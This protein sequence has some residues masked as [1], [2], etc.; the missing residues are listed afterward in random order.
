MIRGL[1]IV[2]VIFYIVAIGT[3][4]LQLI[5][6]FANGINRGSLVIFSE[7][8]IFLVF[9]L[10]FLFRKKIKITAG[11]KLFWKF[12]IIGYIG[13]VIAETAYIFSKPLHKNLFFDLLLVTPWYIMWMICWYFVFKKYDF[14]VKEAFYLGGFHGFVIEGLIAGGLILNPV[15]G[16]LLLPVLTLVYGCFF[17]IPY[18]LT[19]EQFKKQ[20]KVSLGKKVLISLI[21][22][23]AYIPGFIW[24]LIIKGAFGLTLH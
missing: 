1:K 14:T 3:L 15:L 24:I 4:L 2:E 5:N 9:I 20:K 12:L 21:P 11:K 17:I 19:K 18:M 13:C 10:I 6:P 23:V 8:I 22:L 7:L 16:L